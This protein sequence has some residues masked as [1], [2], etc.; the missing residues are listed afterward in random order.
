MSGFQGTLQ[1]SI[2]PEVGTFGKRL[3]IRRRKISN[4][5]AVPTRFG[6]PLC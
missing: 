6:L 2:V 4:K 5:K 1:P 3:N